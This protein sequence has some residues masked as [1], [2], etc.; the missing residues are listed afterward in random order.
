MVGNE[1]FQKPFLERTFSKTESCHLHVGVGGKK[2]KQTVE[3]DGNIG[4]TDLCNCFCVDS[5]TNVNAHVW[6]EHV[7]KT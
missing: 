7:V 6:T 3:K 4:R 1:D 2:G 5:E